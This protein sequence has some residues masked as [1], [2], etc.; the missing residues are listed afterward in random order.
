MNKTFR[1]V[2]YGP[3]LHMSKKEFSGAD[4]NNK[5]CWRRVGHYVSKKGTVAIQEYSW[6]MNSGVQAYT[7]FLTTGFGRIQTMTIDRVNLTDQQLKVNAA[8][9]LRE[10]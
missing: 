4:P 1:S 6:E 9:F 3:W 2:N 8:R 5:N 10:L 7:E